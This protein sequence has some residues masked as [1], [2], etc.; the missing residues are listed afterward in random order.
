[1]THKIFLKI[2]I[3]LALIGFA[4]LYLSIGGRTVYSRINTYSIY[5]V[6]MGLALMVPLVLYF[7]LKQYRRQT[8]SKKRNKTNENRQSK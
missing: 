8:S 1:V 5:P 4:I 7:I 2:A 3:S 6:L